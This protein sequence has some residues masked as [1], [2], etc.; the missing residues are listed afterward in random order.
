MKTVVRRRFRPMIPLLV[1]PLL[2][3]G[4]VQS[5]P[6]QPHF[7]LGGTVIA[8]ASAELR[9]EESGHSL[10]MEVALT[11]RSE[12]VVALSYLLYC[13]VLPRLFHVAAPAEAPAYDGTNRP[14]P[15]AGQSVEVPPGETRRLQNSVPLAELLGAGLAAGRYSVRAHVTAWPD[16][17]EIPAGEVVISGSSLFYVGSS[18]ARPSQQALRSE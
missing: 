14:C 2:I 18:S 12:Q 17:F 16:A 15:R 4:C 7:I 5:N 9:P 6:V 1:F 3:G 10:W 13:P 11:N 8:V